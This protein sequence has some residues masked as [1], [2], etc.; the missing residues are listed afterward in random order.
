[1][2]YVYIGIL[3][4]FVHVISYVCFSLTHFSFGVVFI[5]VVFPF[6]Y[7]SEHF[8]SIY[9]V[10]QEQT[11]FLGNRE[12]SIKKATESLKDDIPKLYNNNL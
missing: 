7:I 8:G 4:Y 1:M 12:L 5:Y 10:S 3:Q 9:P 6:V 11:T 2:S